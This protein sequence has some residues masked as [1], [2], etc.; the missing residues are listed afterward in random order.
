MV[1]IIVVVAYFIMV[2]I[3]WIRDWIAFKLGKNPAMY[4]TMVQSEGHK[5]QTDRGQPI[6]EVSHTAY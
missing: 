5:A 1:A 6:T 4:S 3:H 2:L